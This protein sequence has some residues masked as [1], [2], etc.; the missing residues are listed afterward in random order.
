MNATQTVSALSQGQQNRLRCLV[1][2]V[3][4]TVE[5]RNRDHIVAELLVDSSRRKKEASATTGTGLR[6]CCTKGAQTSVK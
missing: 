4:D 2:M 3:N 1:E 6:K 5:A